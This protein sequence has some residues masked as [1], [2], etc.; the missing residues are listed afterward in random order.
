[1]LTLLTLALGTAQAEPPPPVASEM[2]ERFAVLTDLR[3]HL[4][5]G[6]LQPARDA[7]RTLVDLEPPQGLPEPWR[8]WIAQVKAEA[9]K[10]AEARDHAT[11][12][13]GVGRIAVACSDCHAEQHGGPGLAHMSDLPPQKWS[14]GQNMPLHKWSLDW[15]WL[16]L[17]GPSDEA[18]DRGAGELDKQPLVPKYEDAPPGG[19][20]E[21]EQLVYVLASK[22][23][24]V[25]SQQDR[26]ELY[27]NLIATC[28]QCHVKRD[29][30]EPER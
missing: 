20:R 29:D 5:Q 3:D 7:A 6:R 23:I 24:D 1:M 19:M 28:A 26:G 2:H 15:M 12:A 21:L 9:A 8:P 25:E 22:A 13:E 16:G 14:E 30:Q 10:V 18:W 27:G 4:I 11:A 17:I